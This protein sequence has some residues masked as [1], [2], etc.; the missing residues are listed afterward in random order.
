MVLMHIVD[1]YYLQGILA[2]MKQ[3]SWWEKQEGYKSMYKDDYKMALLMHS[4]SWSIMILLPA[5][6]ILN[7][8]GHML[9]S[10]FAVNT[11]LH[12]IIDN[13][14]AN[15]GRLNLMVDQTLHIAQIIVSWMILC[16]W[17]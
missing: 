10:I 9:W 6:F 15:K 16:Q 14:K 13:E 17:I 5:M 7:V 3:K 8:S 4:M 1:D 12:C 11:L 2:K